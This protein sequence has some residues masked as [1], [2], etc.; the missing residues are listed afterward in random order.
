MKT[1]FTKFLKTFDVENDFKYIFLLL[2]KIYDITFN[3]YTQI[4]GTIFFA[5]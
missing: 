2:P 5:D 4:K 1:N 3:K